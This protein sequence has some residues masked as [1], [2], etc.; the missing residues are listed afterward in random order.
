MICCVCVW[1]RI[2]PGHGLEQPLA[3]EDEGARGVLEEGLDVAVDVDDHM[4]I[5][6]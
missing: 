1:V 6:L 3:R 5:Y 4:C 2:V